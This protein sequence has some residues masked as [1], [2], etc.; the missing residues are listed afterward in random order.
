[1]ALKV[2]VPA[3]GDVLVAV[4]W[5]HDGAPSNGTSGTFA[6][7]AG[8]GDLLS[9]TTNAALYYNTGSSASPTWS[10]ITIP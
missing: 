7:V 10:Q 6:N 8:K 9:D 4:I 1:M 3:L 2:L 5:A